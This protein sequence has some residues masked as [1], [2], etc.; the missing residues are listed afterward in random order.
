MYQKN[1]V[2]T[3]NPRLPFTHWASVKTACSVCPDVL[4]N[5]SLR[6]T[7]SVPEV[8]DIENQ[9]LFN[10]PSLFDPSSIPKMQS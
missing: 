4:C 10:K 2:D 9:V 8:L 7:L 1:I 5:A 3:L 6:I